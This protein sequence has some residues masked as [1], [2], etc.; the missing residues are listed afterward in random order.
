M[1]FQKMLI[2]SLKSIGS[3]YSW[4]ASK[5]HCYNF[6]KLEKDKKYSIN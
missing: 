5:E 3:V 1:N 6:T 2:D 4:Y